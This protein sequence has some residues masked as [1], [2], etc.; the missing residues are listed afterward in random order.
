MHRSASDSD[1][2]KTET[3]DLIVFHNERA[4]NFFAIFGVVVAFLMYDVLGQ[5]LGTPDL[6]GKLFLMFSMSILILM[7]WVA[8]SNCLVDKTVTID[9]NSQS[10]VFQTNS[11][12]KRFESVI[13][14]PFSAL[15]EIK[16]TCY[17]D[18]GIS[19]WQVILIQTYENKPVYVYKTDSESDAHALAWRIYN[20]TGMEIIEKG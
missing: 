2:I 10:I 4:R 5:I 18:E 16:I 11:P 15:K 6:L 19:I 12:I 3:N 8:V 20:I 1:S 9:K 17:N 7:G 13:K 14:I